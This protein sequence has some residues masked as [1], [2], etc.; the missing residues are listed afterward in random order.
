MIRIRTRLTLDIAVWSIAIV[1]ATVT[2]LGTV[3]SELVLISLTLSVHTI[4]ISMAVVH[5]C[6]FV[7]SRVYWGTDHVAR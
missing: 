1:T 3:C 7:A 4:A 5:T 2:D 6:I